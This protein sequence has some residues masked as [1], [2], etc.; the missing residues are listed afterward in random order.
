MKMHGVRRLTREES[1]A[2]TRMRLLASARE[3]MAR[4]GYESVSIDRITEGAGYSKGAFYSNF[5]SKE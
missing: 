5:A 1:R 3:L 4:A 2:L